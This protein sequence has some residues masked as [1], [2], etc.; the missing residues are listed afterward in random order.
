METPKRKPMRLPQYD[1]AA[2]GGY[3]VTVCT[4]GRRRILSKIVGEGLC[5]LPEAALTPIGTEVEKAIRHMETA[6]ESVSVDSYVIMPNHVHLVIMLHKTG[7]HGGP[8][9]HQIIGRFK[10][11]TTHLYGKSLWQRSFYDHILRSEEDLRSARE[12]I[13]A[14]P[15]RWREDELYSEET[16]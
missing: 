14:N 4:E 2:P 6:Y 12:Y 7:G 13:A 9:L 16:L 10:S 3:F 15:A 8:P 1:Y 5:A 11:Y